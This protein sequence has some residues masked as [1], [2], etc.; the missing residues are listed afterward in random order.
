MS[1]LD[2]SGNPHSEQNITGK[3]SQQY[4]VNN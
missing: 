3:N 2:E 4:T 1:L